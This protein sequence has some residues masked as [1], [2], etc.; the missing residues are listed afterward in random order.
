MEAVNDKI[1]DTRAPE[2]YD[3][4]KCLFYDV[5]CRVLDRMAKTAM[6]DVIQVAKSDNP[7]MM[8]VL[9]PKM[10]RFMALPAYC[11]MCSSKAANDFESRITMTF[12]LSEKYGPEWDGPL[13]VVRVYGP[14]IDGTMMALKQQLEKEKNE[15]DNNVSEEV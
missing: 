8:S 3:E 2:G 5:D 1:D 13:R 11:A 10:Q 4:H 6:S 7:M 9:S 14:G 12:K 15:G